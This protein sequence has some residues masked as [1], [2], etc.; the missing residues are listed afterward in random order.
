[1][2]HPNRGFE[3]VAPSME[4]LVQAMQVRR[5]VEIPTM[6]DI[7]RTVSPEAIRPVRRLADAVMQAA[8]E[9]DLKRF[10]ETDYAFH[11]QLTGLCGN[12]ILT[13]FIEELRSRA[14]VVAVPAIARQGVLTDVAQEHAGPA[15]R[16]AGAR[17]G[18]GRAGHDL[19]HGAHL[20]W[21]EGRR[22]RRG[23]TGALRDDRPALSPR[24]RRGARR[25]RG[26]TRT[27]PGDPSTSVARRS[28]RR[29]DDG[30]PR[31][32]RRGRRRAWRTGRCPAPCEPRDQ[33]P[34]PICSNSR[35]LSS[36]TV[37]TCG[38]SSSSR[39]AI[40]IP[41]SACRRVAP[42]SLSAAYASSSPCRAAS[43]AP[44]SAAMPASVEW[45]VRRAIAACEPDSR[46]ASAQALAWS[47]SRARSAR[48]AASP[49]WD[50]A[51]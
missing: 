38:S 50:T 43:T 26:G 33:S 5:L 7:A 28:C 4:Y 10:V 15:E 18:G 30:S 39:V 13:E 32:R 17:S 19:S 29:G 8:Q 22:S 48:M 35:R 2:A 34:A 1:M 25:A 3:V 46:S 12:G 36:T 40:T 45:I 42:R 21:V 11:L 14:R 31:Q 23:R 37:R 49:R 41:V 51:L 20:R 24:P 47:G 16:H 44:S 6:L 27:R 9:G